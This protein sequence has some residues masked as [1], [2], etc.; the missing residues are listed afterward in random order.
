MGVRGDC[1]RKSVDLGVKEDVGV[2][3]GVYRTSIYIYIYIYMCGR[4]LK[5]CLQ[6]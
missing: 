5:R 6:S 3:E 1:S 4:N 2:G